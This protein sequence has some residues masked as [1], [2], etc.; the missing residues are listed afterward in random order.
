[1][2]LGIMHQSGYWNQ[3]SNHS[4]IFKI[5]NQ[6]ATFNDPFDATSSAR[7]SV[8]VDGDVKY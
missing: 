8:H 3:T 5:I 4:L 6:L 2:V 1:M 7:G